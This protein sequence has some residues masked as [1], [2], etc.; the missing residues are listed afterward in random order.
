M[1]STKTAEEWFQ[2]GLTAGRL[3]DDAGAM[4][5]YKEAIKT[6]PD[7]FMSQFNLGIRYGKLRMNLDAA[8]CFRE[9]LRLKPESPMVHYSLAVI[10]N[11][12]GEI[13]E[14]FLH[15][16]EAIRI[17]PEFAKAHSNLAMLHYSLKRG[18]ETIH[19]LI[20]ARKYFQQTG[21]EFMGKNAIDLLQE[22]CRDFN[23]TE[24][25]CQTL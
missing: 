19:H 17:N 1:S 3:K 9:A 13:D 18:K 14:A 20:A 10:S 8:K 7:H 21:D 15:Y 5:S 2:E 4:E 16:K 23:L 11:L 12:I 6:D 24:E 25:E 22:C